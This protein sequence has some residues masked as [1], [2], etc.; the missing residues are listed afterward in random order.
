MSILA[1]AV[2][3]SAAI[4]ALAATEDWKQQF[5]KATD[6]YFEQVVF[7][8]G[9]TGG[10]L[11]GFHQ[12]DAQLE[13][14]SRAN[15]DAEI[16]SLKQFESRIQAIHPGDDAADF[17]PRSDREIVLASIHSQLLELETIRPWEKNADTYS[18]TCASAAFALMERKFASPDDRLRSLIAREKQMPALL[19]EARAN[20]KNPPRIFTEIA[21]EQLPG[22]VDFFQH[23]VPSAFAEASDPAAQSTSSRNR[24]L[25]SSWPSAIISTG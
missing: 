19:V 12:Y 14:Y 6:E 21:I 16:A 22:I 25:P 15:I 20:L 1:I 24:T 8:Y 11:T 13:D 5:A 7:H 9:P 17:V 23:D 3:M 4:P 10:T 18:S 2:A